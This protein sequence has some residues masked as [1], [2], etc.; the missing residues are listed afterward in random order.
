MGEKISLR[1]RPSHEIYRDRN[2]FIIFIFN[3][4]YVENGEAGSHNAEDS[5]LGY[6][7]AWACA[8][9]KSKD[10]VHWVQDRIF[11]EESLRFEDHRVRIVRFVVSDF[12]R[13]KR[14]IRLEQEALK[15]AYQILAITRAPFGIVQDE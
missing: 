13:M 8:P 7:N 11:G 4:L 12:P 15:D 5:R 6:F 2:F 9:S 3:L 1:D 10:K 14:S